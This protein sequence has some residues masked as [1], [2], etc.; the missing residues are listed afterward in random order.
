[1]RVDPENRLVADVLE[2]EWN[3]KLR[4]LSETKE[5]ADRQRER[6]GLRLGQ[7]ERDEVMALVT[8]FPRLWS[9]PRTPDRERKRMVRLLLEDV[10]LQRADEITLHVRFKGGATR[11]LSVPLPPKLADLRRT[12]REIVEEIDRLLE[13]HTDE[14]V[15]E[16]LNAQGL[17]SSEGGAFYP[18]QLA[19]LRRSHQLADRRTRLR[20]RGLLTAQ[21]LARTLDVCADT[22]ERWRRLG[23]IRA[24]RYN[25]KPQY[26]YYPLEG[27]TPVKW[28][29][30]TGRSQLTPQT[31]HG[32][33]S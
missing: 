13:E 21:E 10:T 3:Q 12:G 16:L 25:D 9:D 5:A 33:A 11:T 29:H 23:L 19:Q 20:S 8:S 27:Q 1:M 22:V 2:A 28:K 26:L 15:C 17:R 6:D 31:L 14:E 32:G 30:K 24:E 7:Q 4:A 18:R